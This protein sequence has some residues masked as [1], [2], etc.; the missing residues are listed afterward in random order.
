MSQ[1]VKLGLKVLGLVAG[2][3]IAAACGGGSSG[4]GSGGGSNGGLYGSTPTQPS[5]GGTADVT[6]RITGMNGSNS[7][8]PNP[9]T[10]KAGQTVAW[11]NS[12]SISHTATGAGFDT[13]AIAPGATSAPITF[14]TAGTFSYHC[15]FHPSMVGSL[16]VSQ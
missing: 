6:L 16:S 11:Q 15:S 9:G 13:G 4:S 10:V 1:Q 7:Y 12:D 5:T 2:L 3:A 14:N 8:A